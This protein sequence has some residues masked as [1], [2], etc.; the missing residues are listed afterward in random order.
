MRIDKR[1]VDKPS[2]S[3]LHTVNLNL[4]DYLKLLP[5]LAVFI[6]FATTVPYHLWAMTGQQSADVRNR[7]GAP[8]ERDEMRRAR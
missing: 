8:Q 3:D 7:S 1:T 4:I 6:L 5:W 2:C